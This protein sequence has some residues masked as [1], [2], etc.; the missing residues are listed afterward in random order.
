[1]RLELD[2]EGK[3]SYMVGVR[4]GRAV[5]GGHSKMVGGRYEQRRK[6]LGEV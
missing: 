6:V 3:D 2:F 4:N 1:M 5:G